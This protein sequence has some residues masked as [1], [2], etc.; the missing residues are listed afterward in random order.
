VCLAAPHARRD[1]VEGE[2]ERFPLHDPCEQD[3]QVIGPDV[4]SQAP[5]N[6]VVVRV[7]VF[8]RCLQLLVLLPSG[9]LV[10]S[11]KKEG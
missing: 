9:Q 4:T 2:P 3:S 1:E 5:Q 10:D 8:A 7:L 6:V 11:L